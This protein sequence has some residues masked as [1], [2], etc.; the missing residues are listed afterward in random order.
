MRYN[1][2]EKRMGVELNLYTKIGHFVEEHYYLLTRGFEVLS[3]ISWIIL[4]SN[5]A[6]SYYL[7]VWSFI[8]FMVNAVY[9]LYIYIK[10]DAPFASVYRAGY[11]VSLGIT[12]LASCYLSLIQNYADKPLLAPFIWFAVNVLYCA[13]ASSMILWGINLIFVVFDATERA[14]Y[15]TSVVLVCYALLG[16]LENAFDSLGGNFVISIAVTIFGM[17]IIS[18]VLDPENAR[19]LRSIS[20][21]LYRYGGRISRETCCKII[22]FSIFPMTLFQGLCQCLIIYK[23]GIL[24]TDGSCKRRIL[25]MLYNQHIFYGARIGQ[26]SRK[27]RFSALKHGTL[28]GECIQKINLFPVNVNKGLSPVIHMVNVVNGT[29]HVGISGELILVIGILLGVIMIVV[30]V[31]YNKICARILN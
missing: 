23:N 17:K 1:F 13:L 2:R 15:V 31:L 16:I 7:F 4:F 27:I 22:D 9:S 14:I 30:N 25:L 8:Q 11:T 24:M 10:R 29:L 5:N 18:F 12:V 6:M 28:L 26:I 19:F 20:N 3:L 21:E